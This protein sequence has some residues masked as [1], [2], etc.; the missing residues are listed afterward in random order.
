MKKQI[1]IISFLLIFLFSCTGEKT[2]KVNENDRVKDI[3]SF[4]TNIK[5]KREKV[6]TVSIEGNIDT[7]ID[8]DRVKGKIMIL[9]DKT[10][11]LRIDTISPF[12][13]PVSVFIVNKEKLYYY[14]LEKNTV[15][16]GI[17][18]TQNLSRF[19]PMNLNYTQ[20]LDIFSGIAPMIAY[21]KSDFKYNESDATYDITISDDFEKEEIT[22]IAHN[23]QIKKIKLYANNKKNVSIDFEEFDTKNDI[24][25]A[26]KI[27]FENYKQDTKLKLKISDIIFNEELEESSFTPLEN[28]FK[29]EELE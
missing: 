23:F 1:K 24:S 3:D 15:Y 8:G 2:V 10:K 20:L 13:Q 27:V 25:Y 18:K 16:T 9:V 21:Q 26:K 22:Y 12:E 5:T 17:T 11:G 14:N 4:F 6:K 7:F 29:I 28:N 19:L